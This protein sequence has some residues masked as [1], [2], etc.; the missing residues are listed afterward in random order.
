MTEGQITDKIYHNC[1]TKY[2]NGERKLFD[3]EKSKLCLIPTSQP[4]WSKEVPTDCC[5]QMTSSTKKR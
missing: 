1:A 4:F 5:L 2:S 3:F